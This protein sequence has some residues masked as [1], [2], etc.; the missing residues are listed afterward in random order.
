MFAPLI[1]EKWKNS[2]QA[3]VFRNPV[4]PKSGYQPKNGG[5]SNFL[6][7][8]PRWRLGHLFF[9]FLLVSF[10]V[11]SVFSPLLNI[12]QLCFVFFSRLLR[13]KWFGF[14]YSA[15]FMWFWKKLLTAALLRLAFLPEPTCAALFIPLIISD[16]IFHIIILNLSWQSVILK[17]VVDYPEWWDF[18]Q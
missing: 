1:W 7:G 16:C 4:L 17:A 6:G 2:I 10:G 11:S 18:T 13:H 15:S 3:F 8:K 12:W 5:G 14:C 9:I